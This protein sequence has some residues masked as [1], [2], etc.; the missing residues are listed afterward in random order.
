V[1]AETDLAGL[2]RDAET[3]RR[4]YLQTVAEIDAKKVVLTEAKAGLAELGCATVAE[5]E[6]KIESLQSLLATE[7]DQIRS[8]L[9]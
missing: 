3:A 5:A 1:S 9:T 2:R 4:R 8:L 6:A 7:L